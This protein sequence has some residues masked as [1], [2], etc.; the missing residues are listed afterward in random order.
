MAMTKLENLIKK[1]ILA[2]YVDAKLVDKIQLSPLMTIDRTLENNAGDT[3][4]YP[5]FAY[6]GDADEMTEGTALDTAV[7][8][9]T[10]TKVTVKQAGKAVELSD[11]YVLSASTNVI[12]E[13]IDQIITSIASKIEKDA[14]A[15]LEKATLTHAHAGAV[16]AGVICDAQVK[17]GEDLDEEIYV[18]MNPKNVAAIRKDANFVANMVA[19][20]PETSSLGSK[21]LGQVYGCHVVNSN[22]VPENTMYL[23]KKDALNLVLKRNA[24]VETERDILKKSTVIAGDQHYAVY[25]RNQSKVVKVTITE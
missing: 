15:E 14:F 11:K 4:C 7:L 16:N 10:E 24:E 6:I 21:A 18:F 13:S 5:Q 22:R 8:S 23:V 20:S 17:F 3:V 1:E 25:L 19:Y 2:D 12:D 9:A